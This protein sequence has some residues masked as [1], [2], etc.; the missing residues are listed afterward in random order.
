[1]QINK[2]TETEAKLDAMW[3]D[4]TEKARTI[5]STTDSHEMDYLFGNLETPEEV[6]EFIEENYPDEE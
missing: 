5:I 4:L 6:N 2:N 3:D 1:M